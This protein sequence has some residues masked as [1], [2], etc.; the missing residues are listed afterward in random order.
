MPGGT[1]VTLQAPEGWT[2]ESVSHAL[3]S[4]ARKRKTNEPPQLDEP[5]DDD[6]ER[7]TGKPDRAKRIKLSPEDSSK[8][9]NLIAY[10][11]VHYARYFSLNEE[12]IPVIIHKFFPADL[13]VNDEL[14]VHV[15]SR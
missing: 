11:K 4:Y 14:Y 6:E 5:S 12:E 10:L 1:M 13:R 15:R 3:T 9:Q 2:A 7:T 8:Y